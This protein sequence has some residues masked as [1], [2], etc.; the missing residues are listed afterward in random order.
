MKKKK[1]TF[2]PGPLAGENGREK[3]KKKLMTHQSYGA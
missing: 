3:R 2:P 1:M